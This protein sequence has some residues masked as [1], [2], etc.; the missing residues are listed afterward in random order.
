MKVAFMQAFLWEGTFPRDLSAE[1]EVNKE[2]TQGKSVVTT[3]GMKRYLHT[4]SICVSTHVKGDL[5]K[6]IETQ[7][8]G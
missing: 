2:P 3:T 5:V 1:Q 8:H 4:S 7:L 6:A